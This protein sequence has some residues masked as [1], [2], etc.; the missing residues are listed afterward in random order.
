MNCIKCQAVPVPEDNGPKTPLCRGCRAELILSGEE[1]R[2]GTLDR[3]Y[4]DQAVGRKTPVT[5]EELQSISP[6]SPFGLRNIL[7][8][9]CG[10]TEPYDPMKT[11]QGWPCERCKKHGLACCMAMVVR[12]FRAVSFCKFCRAELELSA[13]GIEKAHEPLPGKEQP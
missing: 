9:V 6:T 4:A 1:L 7:C 5:W 3:A 8:E 12:E 10:K 13:D 2:L 11:R